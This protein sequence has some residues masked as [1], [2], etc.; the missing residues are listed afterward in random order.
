MMCWIFSSC[1]ESNEDRPCD[2]ALNLEP[3][4]DVGLTWHAHGLTCSCMP[5]VDVGWSVLPF[6]SPKAATPGNLMLPYLDLPCHVRSD[7][8]RITGQTWKLEW[9]VAIF[10]SKK[11][12]Y[13]SGEGD[14]SRAPTRCKR[15]ETGSC[16]RFVHFAHER[17]RDW[18][19][20]QLQ[21][22]IMQH[23]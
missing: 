22:I 19:R 4:D 17:F 23:S 18:P 15:R 3:L 20:V 16:Q 21:S 6:P 8:W 12:S 1:H 7:L 9:F 2:F 13:E 14:C 10:G 11:S 5:W